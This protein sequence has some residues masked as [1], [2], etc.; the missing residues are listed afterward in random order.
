MKNP[1]PSL[2]GE[3]L[4]LALHEDNQRARKSDIRE[5]HVERWWTRALL[6]AI[7]AAYLTNFHV[8]PDPTLHIPLW[9]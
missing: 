6:F 7:L 8:A 9:P 2:H 4:T 5:A 3:E 1:Y